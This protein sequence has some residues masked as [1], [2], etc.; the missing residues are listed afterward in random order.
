M[1]NL[2]DV[3]CCEVVAYCHFTGLSDVCFAGYSS[4][5]LTSDVRVLRINAQSLD[6]CSLVLFCL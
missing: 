4:Q 1:I 2:L 6:V 5:L 3:F